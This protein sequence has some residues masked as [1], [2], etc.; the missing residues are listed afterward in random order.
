MENLKCW[1]RRLLKWGLIGL[2]LIIGI[3]MITPSGKKLTVN[4]KPAVMITGMEADRNVTESYNFSDMTGEFVPIKINV[5]PKGQYA[6]VKLRM[7][8]DI[9]KV[10]HVPMVYDYGG[11]HSLVHDAPGKKID[12]GDVPSSFYVSGEDGGGVLEIRC[13]RFKKPTG[14]STASTSS[15]KKRFVKKMRGGMPTSPQIEET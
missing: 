9:Y 5:P 10:P 8:Y 11:V 3:K 13:Y 14:T 15:S 2:V 7:G 6:S 1:G 12:T 4:A